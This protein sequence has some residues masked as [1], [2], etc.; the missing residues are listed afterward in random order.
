M[1]RRP[2]HRRPRR[3]LALGTTLLV[4]GAVAVTAPA[5]VAG[6]GTGS[7]SG[8]GGAG[9]SL[10]VTPVDDLDPA[11]ET[12]T[13]TGT[14]FDAATGFDTATEGLYV[15]LCVDNGPGQQP[16]P[17]IGGV[18]MTGES[19]ASKWVTNNP[20]GSAPSVPISADGSFTT[21]VELARADEFTDCADLQ[22]GKSCKV[23]VR[24]DHR[25]SGDRS[26]DVRVPV[27]F[28][29]GQPDG[30]AIALAPATGLDPDG[31]DV[32]VTG[33]GF[34]TEGPG[35]QVVFGPALEDGTGPDRFG[36]QVFV[37]SSAIAP[38]GSFTATL[39][40]VTAAYTAADGQDRDFLDGGGF[41]S[42]LRA[43][44]Q[45]DPDGEWETSE[46]VAFAGAAVPATTTSLIVSPTTVA[47]GK[48]IVMTAS[49]ETV[50]T[51]STTARAT[52]QAAVTSGTVEWRDGATSL[53]TAA[54]GPDGRAT[55]TATFSATGAHSITARFTGT[56]GAAAST[57]APVVVTVTAAPGPGPGPG[58][59]P[60]D[61][62]PSGTRTGTGPGG[63]TL[64]A[65]PVDDLDPAGTEV[66]VRGAG[67]TAGA[68]FDI[69]TEGMYVSFCVDQ[70]TGVQPS[71]CVGGVDMEG[72][73]GSSTWVT[74]NPYDGLPPEAVTSVAPDGSFTTRITVAAA[75]EFVDCLDLPAGQRC[76]IVS[77]MDHRATADRSQDVKVP[78]CFA[79]EAE[80]TTD[81][82]DPNAP[83]GPG[84]EPFAGYALG[85]SNGLGGSTP[86]ATSG[87]AGP[88]AATGFTGRTLVPAGLALLGVGAALVL[89]A[90]RQLAALRPAVATS[91]PSRP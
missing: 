4:A 9:Q 14:G 24:M 59:D 79:G 34:P 53:G 11:G 20:I 55:R 87:G 61:E 82:I 56:A 10:T 5:L 57:S 12:V 21:T 60:S 26:Q 17:C 73:S 62:T 40:D 48:P 54:L 83:G 36:A 74:N 72:A 13:V 18:D 76:V 1:A 27:T 67:F 84:S 42:T 88:L 71:P 58:P 46:P 50:A 89:V 66:E 90:R 25:A 49:V 29:D 81:P 47:A 80:C 31:T 52:P 32:T 3:L 41:V 65:T 23:F 15:A 86:L 43:E 78:V 39:P 30:A 77:R 33:T 64:T 28:G 51:S 85:P 37:P 38:D 45:A 35:V 63:Q 16:M 2:A 22:A 70:G 69:A 7:G 91:G 6:A 44:G 68:G 8:T 75:D 19:G